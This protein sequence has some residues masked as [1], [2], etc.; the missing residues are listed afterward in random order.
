MLYLSSL[1]QYYA[2]L[3]CQ[4]YYQLSHY[5]Q[6]NGLAAKYV[7][8]V[9]SLF[10]KAKE[11]GKDFFKHLTIY[12]NTPLMGSMQSPMQILQ[13][14]NAKFEL[15]MSNAARQQLGIQPEIV[16][17]TDKHQVLSTHDLHV[18]QQVMYQNS[19]SKHWYPAV[20]K[21]LCSETR[22]YKII[23]SDVI[24]YRKPQTHL[25][26]FTPQNKMS[27]SSMCV[28][29]PLA[30]CNHMWP[31]KTES[32]KKSQV[33]NHIQVQTSRPKRDTTPPVKLDLSLCAYLDMYYFRVFTSMHK[34]PC[35]RV[36][37]AKSYTSMCMHLNIT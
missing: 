20:I 37:D 11:E 21:S 16:R 9:K 15:S 17:N 10:Y 18:E 6:S 23:T 29:S 4:S 2:V 8:I 22:S 30:K 24:V 35:N 13:G 34:C 1:H 25:K 12:Y 3:R 7:Q 33:N 31:V 28:S 32:K 14:R 27:Q 19:M 5:P 26:P 36:Q